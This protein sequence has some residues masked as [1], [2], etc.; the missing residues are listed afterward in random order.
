MKTITIPVTLTLAQQDID[1]IVCTAL[2]GGICCWCEQAEVIGEVLEKYDYA[3]QVLTRGGQLRLHTWDNKKY[4]LTLDKLKEGVSQYCKEYGF[5]LESI[6]A[7]ASD[8]I[9]QY[10][11]FGKRLHYD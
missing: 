6:D 2:E 3:S 1:D 11:L 8:I 4:I 10:A 5:D 7:P 9:I